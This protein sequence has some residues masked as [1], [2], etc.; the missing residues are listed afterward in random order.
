M[1]VGLT[2]QC[3]IMIQG[4]EFRLGRNW[5]AVRKG[6]AQLGG[7]RSQQWSQFPVSTRLNSSHSLAG[8]VYQK[9]MSQA[10][11]AQLRPCHRCCRI[12]AK[13]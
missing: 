9:F 4:C 12:R 11:V 8:A 6:T 2:I 5:F 10:K 13:A 3:P 1:R 7:A